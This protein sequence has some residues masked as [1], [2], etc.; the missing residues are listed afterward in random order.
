M[1]SVG[2]MRKGKGWMLMEVERRRKV[3]RM[4]QV[5][6]TGLSRPLNSALMLLTCVSHYVPEQLVIRTLL[7]QIVWVLIFISRAQVLARPL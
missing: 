4:M 1:M 2:P 5:Y 7:L 6:T 3:P